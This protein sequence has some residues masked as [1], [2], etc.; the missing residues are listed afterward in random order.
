MYQSVTKSGFD[1]YYCMLSFE[2]NTQCHYSG[3]P[4]PLAYAMEMEEHQNK[5]LSQKLNPQQIDRIIEMAW[6]DRTPFDAIRQQF[7]VKEDEVKAIMKKNLRLKSY[8]NWRKRVE[9][10][11]TKHSKKR[12]QGINRFKCTRQKAISLNKISKR[13]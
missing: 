8:Q 6:E 5:I 10:C 4:S 11:K 13:K 1:C 7:G 3:L 12:I 9:H 2:T